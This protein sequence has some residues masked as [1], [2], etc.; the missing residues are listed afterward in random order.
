MPAGVPPLTSFHRKTDRTERGPCLRKR[1]CPLLDSM[2]SCVKVADDRTLPEGGDIT[3]TLVEIHFVEVVTRMDW[4]PPS[5]LL[6]EMAARVGG[7]IML[8]LG[9]GASRASLS[10]VT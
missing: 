4:V 1:R 9:Y 3:C 8:Q 2:Q 7:P 6:F 5:G 10:P